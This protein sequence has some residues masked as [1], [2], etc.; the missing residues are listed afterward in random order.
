MK[1]RV[2]QKVGLASICAVTIASTFCAPSFAIKIYGIVIP[3][4]NTFPVE[5]PR[6]CTTSNFGMHF[7]E[8]PSYTDN[9]TSAQATFSL[10]YCNEINENITIDNPGLLIYENNTDQPLSAIPGRDVQYLEQNLSNVTS[11]IN[12][13]SEATW[14]SGS[15]TGQTYSDNIPYTVQGLKPNTE[16]VIL[17]ELDITERASSP[18]GALSSVLTRNF[19]EIDITVTADTST[20]IRQKIVDKYT[21][22]TDTSVAFDHKFAGGNYDEI[23]SELLEENKADSKVAVSP[24]EVDL[25]NGTSTFE[26]SNLKPNTFYILHLTY[27]NGG[28]AV[29]ELDLVFSTFDK[30]PKVELNDKMMTIVD[31]NGEEGTSITQV[32]GSIRKN[33]DGSDEISF[34]IDG[35][36]IKD[37]TDIL[38]DLSKINI[39]LE[40]NTEYII[41]AHVIHENNDQS[42]G[43]EEEIEIVFATDANGKPSRVISVNGNAVSTPETVKSAKNPSTLDPI[44]TSIAIL[45]IAGVAA[46]AFAKYGKLS[47]R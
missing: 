16:Y 42:A 47:R 15:T 25:A 3:A 1:K 33:I 40:P 35:D 32:D 27:K 9:G 39:E 21:K 30:A 4:N 2:L 45:T 6:D 29:E 24:K 37:G 19:A 26:F 12:V 7:N 20:P 46:A 34:N 11:T 43:T 10:F 31:K 44:V 38:L 41:N 23:E 13:T 17:A 14:G 22:R 5:I 8:N 28:D 36:D 18:S